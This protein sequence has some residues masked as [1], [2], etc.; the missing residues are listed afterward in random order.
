MYLVEVPHRVTCSFL[1][2][3]PS[4]ATELIR[5]I[6]FLQYKYKGKR[7][8]FSVRFPNPDSEPAQACW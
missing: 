5:K 8:L 6:I 3:A 7:V 2:V 4:H 1:S